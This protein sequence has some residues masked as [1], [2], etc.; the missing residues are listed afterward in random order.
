MAEPLLN[1]CCRC[2][3]LRTGS[4][5]SGICGIFLA[6]AALVAMFFT[7]VEMK[8]IIIDWLPSNIVKIILTI[9]L[10][11][12]VIICLVMIFGVVKVRLLI[13]IMCIFVC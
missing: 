13:M 5:I 3:S 7:R 10:C 4:I 8:T 11:M 2:Q 9:N 1:S 6:L 12:T